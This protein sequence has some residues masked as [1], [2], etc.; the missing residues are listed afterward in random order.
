MSRIQTVNI[1]VP[2]PNPAKSVGTTAI[3][4]R[5]IDGPIYVRAPGPKGT[6]LGSGIVD[7]TVFDYAHHGG[8]D[9][10]VYAYAREDLDA[11]EL[12]LQR[13]LTCG[14][15]GENI[16]TVGVDLTY[17]VI[18]QRWRVGE[19]VI[20][21]VSGPRKPCGTFAHWMNEDRWVKRF[22]AHG[23]PGAFLRVIEEGEIKPG[24]RV[25]VIHTPTH[26]VTID[27]TFRALLVDPDLLSSL[28]EADALPESIKELA[29]RRA[30]ISSRSTC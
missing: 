11:W 4:R 3:D 2:R 30:R 28:L 24:D 19:Q 26:D 13:E 14:M 12:T 23:A 9:Q 15:F 7:D 8:D 10:A 5:P 22:I 16:T 25:E 18:G 29:R 17:A 20:L 6:G 1:G 27:L 21:E